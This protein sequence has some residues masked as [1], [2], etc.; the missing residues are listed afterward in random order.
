MIQD[1]ILRDFSGDD[2]FPKVAMPS[3]RTDRETMAPVFVDLVHRLGAQ[4]IAEMDDAD[5]MALIPVF[6]LLGGQYVVI[7][8]A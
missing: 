8:G 5:V 6:H 1:E 7:S 2:I 4:R 3:A